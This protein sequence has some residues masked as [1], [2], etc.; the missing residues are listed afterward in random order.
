MPAAAESSAVVV[1]TDGAEEENN[2]ETPLVEA[3]GSETS[4]ISEPVALPDTAAAA[5]KPAGMSCCK[6]VLFTSLCMVGS[7]VAFVGIGLQVG[8]VTLEDADAESPAP[9]AK[10]FSAADSNSA[11]S[12]DL[13]PE[14]AYLQGRIPSTAD[15]SKRGMQ[16]LVKSKVDEDSSSAEEV[17]TSGRPVEQ[18]AKAS[19]DVSAVNS[20]GD[21]SA[22]GNLSHVN[23]SNGNSSNI[24]N[25]TVAK[26]K[27]HKHLVCKGGAAAV[28]EC[29]FS[30]EIFGNQPGKCDSAEKVQL[31]DS[32]VQKALSSTATACTGMQCITRCSKRLGCYDEK[33]QGDCRSLK[34]RTEAMKELTEGMS[35]GESSGT[36]NLECDAEDGMEESSEV[37]QD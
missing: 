36:C 19:K 2:S 31:L 18:V 1:P 16:V 8:F 12:S 23:V 13:P 29:L 25:A 24:T 15:E 6:K 21:A 5:S 28:C 35:E 37:L 10:E 32:L 7:F 27:E 26:K 20:T 33:V 17:S 22:A 4:K 9:A 14:L 3:A 11:A 30:C 34:E